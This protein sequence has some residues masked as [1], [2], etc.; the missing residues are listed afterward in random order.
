MAETVAPARP[1][2]QHRAA[3]RGV[4]SLTGAQLWTAAALGVTLVALA[5]RLYQI[6]NESLWLDE[7]YTLL[8]SRLRLDRL[9]V[10]GGAHEHPPLY[11]LVVHFLLD[12]RN[13]LLVPRLVSAIAGSLSV[14]VLYALGTQLAGRPAGLTAAALLAIA[15]F[16]VWYGQD[17]RAY[18]L[19]GLLVLLSYL[20]VFRALQRPRRARWIAYALCTAMA[21]YTEY[22]TILVLLPQGL[23]LFR[24]WRSG[25]GGAL[26][27]AWLGAALVFAPWLGVLVADASSIAG[28]YWIP[29]PTRGDVTNTTLEF[30]GTR[31]PCPS[32]PC[33]GSAAVLPL[34]TG[35]EST[36]AVVTIALVLGLLAIAALRRDLTLSVLLLWLVLPFALVLLI[37]SRR[38]LYLDRVFLDATFPLYLLLG[39][40]A[41]RSWRRR[42][43]T[44][45]DGPDESGPYRIWR[46]MRGSAG[47]TTIA[48]VL[49]LGVVNVANVRLVYSNST[50]PD[51]KTATRDLLS[52]Y[53]PGQSVV[54]NPAVLQTLVGMY[55]PAG[56]HATRE[57]PVWSHSYLDVAGWQ[58]QYAPIAATILNDQRLALQLRHARLDGIMRDRQMATAT[59]GERQ[60]WL[61]TQDYSGMSDSRIWLRSHGFQLLLSEIYAGDT[62]LELWDRRLPPDFGPAALADDGFGR[63]WR[64]TGTVSVVGGV[65]LQRG[66]SALERSLSVTPGSA[67][68]VNVEYRAIPPAYPVISVSTY[69]HSGRPVGTMVDRFGYLWRSFPRTEW[70][71]LPV[72][73]AWLSQPFGFVAPPEAV[74]ATLRAENLWG[75]CYWRHLAVYQEQ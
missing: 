44:Q 57:Q 1:G 26:L 68:T 31:T 30:L 11:Y 37:S 71:N 5:L 72:N 61:V 56:W 32:P 45:R 10:I 6:G 16:H 22:T 69:D 12:L 17:G 49:A 35:H 47:V 29:A 15:P 54:F 24:A 20:S 38:S 53:R 62:R 60:V 55:L 9:I 25:M 4:G 50:N 23:L 41:A 67:Y 19:A 64:R 28:N 27:R 13:S 48:L 66:R 51:W 39:A 43:T 70:Y 74:R 21:L 58:K 73:G 59:A 52:A 3:V 46:W 65:A 7:G 33:T 34:L 63:S 14:L 42:G 18:E 2:T 8:F 36:F 40:L 75:D